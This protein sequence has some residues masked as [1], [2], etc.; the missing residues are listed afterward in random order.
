MPR[1]KPDDLNAM[2]LEMLQAM[3]QMD[4]DADAMFE[5][6]MEMESQLDRDRAQHLAG[7]DQHHSFDTEQDRVAAAHRQVELLGKLYMELRVV[8]NPDL[9]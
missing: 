7:R 4:L 8:T 3:S 6:V 9:N 1:K 2:P 5:N